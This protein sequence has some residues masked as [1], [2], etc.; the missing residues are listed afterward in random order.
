MD[1]FSLPPSLLWAI[2]GLILVGAEVFTG[3]FILLFLGVAAVLVAIFKAFGLSNLSLE[4]ILFSVFSLCGLILFRR[5]LVQSFSRN[6]PFSID[7]NKILI[8]SADIPV[9]EETEIQY[10]GAPWLAFN[11]GPDPLHKG[12]RVWIERTEGVK[13]IVRPMKQT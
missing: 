6:R 3:T 5:K 11:P 13:L 2:L 7:E 8:L 10:Q 9:G 4:I 12:D 1:G